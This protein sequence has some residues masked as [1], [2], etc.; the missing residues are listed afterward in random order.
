M[1]LKLKTPDKNAT[2]VETDIS[3]SN[4]HEKL[5][6]RPEQKQCDVYTCQVLSLMC[7]RVANVVA[8][9]DDLLTQ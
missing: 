1:D 4:F 9:H 2:R 6:P 5:I 3:C 8:D 7:I